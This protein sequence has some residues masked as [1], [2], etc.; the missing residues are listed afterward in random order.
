MLAFALVSGLLWCACASA[1]PALYRCSGTQGETVFT[2]HPD[3][4]R[5]CGLISDAT[6]SP[7][8]AKTVPTHLVIQSNDIAMSG[9][10]N[11]PA[12]GNIAMS[13]A[14]QTAGPETARAAKP[15]PAVITVTPLHAESAPV[16]R[17]LPSPDVDVLAIGKPWPMSV[18]DAIAT[19]LLPKLLE[20][21]KPA[22]AAPARSA[23]TQP[24]NTVVA[25]PV[26]V[27]A[28]MPAPLPAPKHGAVYKIARSDGTIE[29]TNIA[30]RAQGTN[31]T[32]L[33]TYLIR[34][35][36]CNVHSNVDWNTVALHLKDYDDQ[37]HAAAAKAGVGEALLRAVIHAESGFNPR[38]MSYKGA[39]GLM[40][41]MPGT[42]AD[43][44]VS[45]AFDIS[46]N[47]GG[48]A[49]YLAQLLHDFKGDVT[50]AAAAYNA[51]EAAVRKY[52][53]VP[54][55]DETQVYVKRVAI[56]RDRYLKALHPTALAAAGAQ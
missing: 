56:L 9:T 50:L 53:G 47:I 16:V 42:A 6:M 15:N 22:A 23:L 45:D 40:Q 35:Y 38:A 27:S 7:H 5:H 43:M 24:A 13:T 52:N 37:I 46:Q 20:P 10:G 51:G 18:L 19:D 30:A 26:T 54:P 36:A 34:C 44:G 48:G 28:T 49:K 21:R 39:Q 4:Y 41:L 12:V 2:S 31:A 33:F 3:Q 14:G 17:S 11:T 8:R 25:A 55:Y 1:H 29:Y 32:M